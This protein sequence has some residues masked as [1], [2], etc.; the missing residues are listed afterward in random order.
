MIRTFLIVIVCITLFIIWSIFG[1]CVPS[2][3]KD[4]DWI[5]YTIGETVYFKSTSHQ[6][7]SIYIADIKTLTPV[8][9]FNFFNP[10]TIVVDGIRKD[11]IITAIHHKEVI[12]D[13]YFTLFSVTASIPFVSEQHISIGIK[14]Y[15]FIGDIS[16]VESYRLDSIELEGHY[17]KDAIKLMKYPNFYPTIDSTNIE[18]VYWSKEKGLIGYQQYDGVLWK[19][20]EN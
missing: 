5:S 15:G 4:K 19:K 8:G 1:V 7:D 10:Q 3:Q 2:T 20:V 17:Y 13:N 12:R 6:V 18:I 9:T 16:K 14:D 11:S